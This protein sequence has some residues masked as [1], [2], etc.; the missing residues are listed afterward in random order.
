MNSDLD[1][2][3]AA[4]LAE[5]ENRLPRVRAGLDV[6]FAN[7]AASRLFRESRG[8]VWMTVENGVHLRSRTAASMDPKTVL[9]LGD[10]CE[11]PFEDNQF[12]VVLL[13][14]AML[15]QHPARVASLVREIHRVLQGGGCLIFAVDEASSGSE[16]YS[17]RRIYELLR[18]GFDVVGLKRP[19]WWRFGRAGRLMTVCARRKNWRNR[20]RSIVNASMPVSAA[21]LSPR[22]RQRRGAS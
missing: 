11:L 21:V 3:E 13:S 2:H 9:Q 19:P 10:A 20:G 14:A 12:E 7:P 18:D 17:Q 8:G 1:K 5:M 15:R 6:G 16:G 22:D 4:V